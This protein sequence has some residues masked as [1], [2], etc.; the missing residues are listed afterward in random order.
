M[1]SSKARFPK[2]RRRSIWALVLLV[3]V[4]LTIGLYYNNRDAG[5][6]HTV[7]APTPEIRDK[8]DIY[9]GAGSAQFSIYAPQYPG[10]TIIE[11]SRFEDS[12]GTMMIASVTT[13]DTVRQ[14]ADY[15]HMVLKEKGFDPD[16]TSD[17]RGAAAHITITGVRPSAGISVLVTIQSIPNNGTRIDLSDTTRTNTIP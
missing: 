7:S 8:P 16:R 15:Y 3:S 14:V 17:G 1:S 9:V 13:P 11:A 10:S 12:T 2:R 6:S 5:F 4:A